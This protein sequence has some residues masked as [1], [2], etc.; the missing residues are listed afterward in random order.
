M[1]ADSQIKMNFSP[2]SIGAERCLSE[3]EENRRI[4]KLIL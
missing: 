4:R 2:R 3:G 1:A